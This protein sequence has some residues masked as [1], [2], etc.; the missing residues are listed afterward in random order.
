M[1]NYEI[2]TELIKNDATDIQVEK[3]KV[4]ALLYICESLDTL[5][6]AVHDIFGTPPEAPNAK[7]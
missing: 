4:Y 3:A 6:K 7:P 1:D 2:A 5:V